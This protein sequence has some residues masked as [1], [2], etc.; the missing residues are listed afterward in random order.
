MA[1]YDL[2]ILQQGIRMRDK[3]S[4]G[5]FQLHSLY[6]NYEKSCHLLV[7]IIIDLLS[8]FQNRVKEK[9]NHGIPTI[10]N[11]ETPTQCHL[12]NKKGSFDKIKVTLQTYLQNYKVQFHP[13][14][15]ILKNAQKLLVDLYSSYYCYREIIHENKQFFP[16]EEEEESST[17]LDE[18]KPKLKTPSTT[19]S[20]LTF[21]S[22]QQQQ[23]KDKDNNSSSSPP[24]PS[25]HPKEII[26]QVIQPTYFYEHCTPQNL[27][28]IIFPALH[29]LITP[30]LYGTPSQIRFYNACSRILNLC[31]GKILF[32]FHESTTSLIQSCFTAS[33]SDSTSPSFDMKTIVDDHENTMNCLPF[34]NN[35]S[36]HPKAEE[37]QDRYKIK[38]DVNSK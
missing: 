32:S 38:G 36:S 16:E 24:P 27:S 5:D 6:Q 17:E 30:R 33:S 20:L 10:E 26:D 21:S 23:P 1:I 35:S 7:L 15:F 13:K 8:T 12:D 3:L 29:R 11:N 34:M 18:T 19:L 31:S 25:P 28:S 14:S 37:D 4:H 9:T 22:Q 2:F